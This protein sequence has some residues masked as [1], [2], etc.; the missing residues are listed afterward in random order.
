MNKT[1]AFLCLIVLSCAPSFAQEDDSPALLANMELVGSAEFQFLFWK[2]YEAELY[3]K[4]GEYSS[5]E[6]LPLA[7]KLSY[8]K[9]FSAENLLNETEKQF[10]AL[11]LESARFE[12]WLQQLR[13]IFVSVNPGDALLLYID[14]RGFSHFYYNEEFLGSIPNADFSQQFSAIWLAREDRYADFSQ[15]LKGGGS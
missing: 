4:S 11:G 5:F 7:L 14:S 10:I 1:L 6:E 8:N 9:S 13:N 2:I 15:R 3:S 12:S